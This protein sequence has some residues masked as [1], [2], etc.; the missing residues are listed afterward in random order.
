MF[1]SQ[2]RSHVQLSFDYMESSE[3]EQVVYMYLSTST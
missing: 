3:E 2:A 1:L